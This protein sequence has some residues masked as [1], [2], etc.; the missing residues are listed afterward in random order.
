MAVLADA[1]YEHISLMLKVVG[2]GRCTLRLGPFS[3]YSL[4][5]ASDGAQPT[6]EERVRSVPLSL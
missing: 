2:G 3:V 4:K 5:H 6:T 1:G